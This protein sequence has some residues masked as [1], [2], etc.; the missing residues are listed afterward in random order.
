MTRVLVVDDHGVVRAGLVQLLGSVDEIEVAGAATNG[1][2]AV[3]LAASLAPDLVLMDLSMPVMDGVEATRQ[4]VAAGLAPVLVLT[5]FSD[6]DRI[7][8]ALDAGASGYVL[9]DAEPED[10]VRAIHSAARGDLPLDPKVARALVDSRRAAPAPRPA[11]GS[12]LTSREREVLALV[13]EGLA[14]KLIARRLGI[15]EKTVKAHLTPVF[16]CLGVTDRTQAALYAHREGLG[17]ET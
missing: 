6:Q 13:G 12:G 4:I 1:A 17:P 8:A 7:V 11:P 10:L 9:K 14:N 3:A 15:S 2:E 16:H 5:S